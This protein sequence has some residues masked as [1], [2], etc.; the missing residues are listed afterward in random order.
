MITT[1]LEDIMTNSNGEKETTP[2][3]TPRSKMGSNDV[4]TTTMEINSINYI[5]NI[6]QQHH[7]NLEELKCDAKKNLDSICVVVN[8]MFR[9]KISWLKR[10]NFKACKVW[11]SMINYTKKVVL[12]KFNFKK[13]SFQHS[14]SKR[15]LKPI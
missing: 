3:G 7:W 15:Y 12:W 10:Q 1:F 5:W 8:I 13:I 9:P 11:T 4:N 14:H 2:W 6:I